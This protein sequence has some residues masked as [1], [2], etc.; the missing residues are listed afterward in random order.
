[1]GTT[2]E[3]IIRTCCECKRPYD[4]DR[5]DAGDEERYCSG[6]CEGEHMAAHAEY[7]QEVRHG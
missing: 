6:V 4:E 1:M 3:R 7:Q 2:N 5:S